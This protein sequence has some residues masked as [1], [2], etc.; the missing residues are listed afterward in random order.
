MA[1]CLLSH[2]T[3]P[4]RSRPGGRN[5]RGIKRPPGRRAHI[6]P[7]EGVFCE[8]VEGKG[9]TSRKVFKEGGNGK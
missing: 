3:G 1:A 4:D 9:G 8:G 7:L 2:S 6:R 5:S